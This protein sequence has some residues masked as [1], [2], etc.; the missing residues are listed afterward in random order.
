[1][2]VPFLVQPTI[3]A[4]GCGRGLALAPME[5]SCYP[6]PMQALNN[7]VDLSSELL[8]D[9]GLLEANPDVRLPKLPAEYTVGA[10]STSLAP[11]HSL[12]ATLVQNTKTGE[13]QWSCRGEA[14]LELAH[15]LADLKRFRKNN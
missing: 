6:E 14:P 4:T 11:V 8:T 1:M 9:I 12:P 13:Q 5:R 15:V 3:S 10:G 7:V 2:D